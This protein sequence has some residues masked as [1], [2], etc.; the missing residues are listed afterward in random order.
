MDAP[1]QPLPTTLEQPVAR[2]AI[3]TLVVDDEAHVRCYLRTM[4]RGLG[5]TSITE[6]AN[7]LEAIEV[8]Q[9]ERPALVLLDI[10]M[11]KMR[12]YETLERILQIEPE[13]AVVIVSEQN[14]LP[15]IRQFQELGALSFVLKHS[16]SAQITRLLEEILDRFVIEA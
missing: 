7:G 16:P 13:A 11:P 1:H 4:L 8:F 15:V 6:A 10:N 5:V 12:G 3:T 2:S 9:R 14:E